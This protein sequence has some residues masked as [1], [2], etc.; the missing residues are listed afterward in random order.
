MKVAGFSMDAR[1]VKEMLANIGVYPDKRL[2]QTFLVDEDV[3]RR[4]A[5]AA[6]VAGKDTVLEIGPGLGI[7]TEELCVLA[8]RVIAVEKDRRLARYLRENLQADNLQVIEGDIL[9]VDIPSYDVAVGNLPYS[10]SSPTIFR[11]SEGGMKRGLFMIQ[12]EVAERTVAGPFTAEY[13]RMSASLQRLYEVSL[14]FGV[15]HSHFYPQPDV[16]SAVIRLSRR[17]GA[18]LWPEFDYFVGLLFSQRRKTINSILR[19]SVA[20]YSGMSERAPFGEKRVEELSIAQ[21]EELVGW[22]LSRSPEAL[23]RN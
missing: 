6:G 11:L 8:G 5:E 3:A 23:P 16:D 9:E 1:T 4:E 2:G 22:L 18:K 15:G 13:S 20:G 10:V 21:M 19:K 14:L 17:E 7:L 12:R